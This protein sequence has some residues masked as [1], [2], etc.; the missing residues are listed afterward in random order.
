MLD[1]FLLTRLYNE[2]EKL[3]YRKYLEEWDIIW[4]NTFGIQQRIWYSVYYTLLFIF[5][6]TV[7]TIAGNVGADLQSVNADNHRRNFC[8]PECPLD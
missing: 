4:T 2:T 8:C 7:K 1:P 3:L 5:D 6:E